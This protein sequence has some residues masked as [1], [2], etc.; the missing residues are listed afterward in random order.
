VARNFVTE[1]EIE[2]MHDWFCERRHQGL[3]LT[4][5]NGDPLEWGQESEVE[6]DPI[7]RQL[8]GNPE[9]FKERFPALYQR[10]VHL[11]NGLGSMLKM[12]EEE[13]NRVDFAQD[14]RYITYK[15]GTAIS[16]LLSFVT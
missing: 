7:V 14:I 6:G 8:Y 15:D 12:D 5:F 10:V 16:L 13:L 1:A 11:K 3:R 4:E 2:E 9:P